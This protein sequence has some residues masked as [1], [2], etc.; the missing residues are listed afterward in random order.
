MD[1][2]EQVKLR[3][4]TRRTALLSLGAM[5]GFGLLFSRLYE[6]QVLDADQYKVK[7][8]EN[9]VKAR[10][11]APLRGRILDRFGVEVAGNSQNLRVL[12]IPE[13]TGALS[14]TDVLDKLGEVV[15]LSEARRKRILRDVKRQ[16]RFVPVTVTENL[17]WQDFAQVNL[18]SPELPGIQ[19]EVGDTRFYPFGD[20]LAHVLGYVAAV[21]E[22]DLDD[23]P[24]LRLPGF[25]VGKNGVEKKLDRRLRGAKGTRQVEVN[26]GGRIIRELSRVDGTPGEDAVLTLD[27]D[28][29][30]VANQAIEGESGA[31][32]AMNI[33]TGEVLAL[34]AAPGFDPSAFNRGLSHPEWNAL[35]NNPKKPLIN[36]AVAGL[37][38][39]GSV[40]K[41]TVALA[42]L[43]HGRM[44]RNDT[45]FCTG[46]YQLGNHIFHCWKREGHGAMNMHMGIKHS[47]DV[48]FYELARRLGIDRMAETL[49]QFGLGVS[50]DFELPGE[51]EGQVPTRGWK[52][53]MTGQPWVR[54]ETL[55]TGIGQGY[56][57]ST[58]LQLAVMTARLANG[59]RAVV[60]RII[61]SCGEEL[62]IA[63][64]EAE[65]IDADP[66]NIRF[67]L[68]AMNAVTNDWRGTAFRSRLEGEGM[69]MAGKTGTAQ[70]RRITMAERLVGVR[71]NE[72]LPWEL[73]DHALF[74]GYG[75]VDNPKYA[76]AVI[77]EHGGSGSKAAAP[78]ARDVMRE[79]LIKDPASKPPVGPAGAPVRIGEETDTDS[80]RSSQG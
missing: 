17:D 65:R 10:M 80:P 45:V 48:Y 37:F 54:G 27:M 22:R 28:I 41:P 11:L 60:P 36:K 9:R 18:L 76:V 33:H 64:G 40:V 29:Q 7:A 12:L 13:D 68:N 8:E 4:F 61:R 71:K 16:A 35:L 34:A 79:M 5:G 32:V 52:L 46:K 19:P 49:K 67:V 55:N 77:V 44:G 78:R 56:M 69:S 14:V 51:K 42:A 20:D 70:V 50:Y 39:P 15:D 59:G 3:A 75:P 73:R 58:P 43:E 30:R 1:G 74:A 31:I 62:M 53:A 6:L 23:D 47:C 38:P 66:G 63:P 25:R 2:R 24:L 72:D 21:S 26:A 57:L